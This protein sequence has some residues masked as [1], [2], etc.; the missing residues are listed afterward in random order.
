MIKQQYCAYIPPAADSY[1]GVNTML[2]TVIALSFVM[3]KCTYHNSHRYVSAYA[4]LS[5]GH[6]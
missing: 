5:L 4:C 6:R 2:L 3:N 1:S